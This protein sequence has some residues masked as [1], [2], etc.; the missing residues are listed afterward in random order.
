VLPRPTLRTGSPR[1]AA[2]LAAAG[3]GVAIVP[4]SALTPCP[5]GVIRSFD[6]PELRDVVVIVAAP[7]DDLVRRF[8][9]DVKERGLPAA[10]AAW[11]AAPAPAAPGRQAAQAPAAEAQAAQPQATEPRATEP[12]ATEPRATEPR[13][14]EPRMLMAVPGLLVLAVFISAM[15][16]S[17]RARLAALLINVPGSFRAIR[18][19]SRKREA[20]NERSRAGRNCER[21]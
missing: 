18:A 14:P 13:A 7:H 6:P 1:T 16:Y 15:N 10:S 3:L 11:P 17:K 9:G 19:A 2:Q 4:V 12:R 5:D 8:V 21:S 20:G